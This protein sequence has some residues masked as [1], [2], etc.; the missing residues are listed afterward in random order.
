MSEIRFSFWA[1]WLALFNLSDWV[2]EI[3][4]FWSKSMV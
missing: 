3:L 2:W 4:K 1:R